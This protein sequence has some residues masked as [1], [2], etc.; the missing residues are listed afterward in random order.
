MMKKAID[1]NNRVYKTETRKEGK[2]VDIFGGSYSYRND[3]KVVNSPY[4]ET[5]KNIFEDGV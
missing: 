1:T 5:Y 3:M 2:Y 4:N